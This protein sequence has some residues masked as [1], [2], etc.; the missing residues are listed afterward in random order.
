MRRLVGWWFVLL[1]STVTVG[2][3]IARNDNESR[4]VKHKTKDGW[5]VS[6]ANKKFADGKGGVYVEMQ[7]GTSLNDGIWAIVVPYDKFRDDDE[8]LVVDITANIALLPW[9]GRWN[10]E[11]LNLALPDATE[12]LNENGIHCRAI[13]VVRIMRFIR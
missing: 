6:Q 12:I 11:A 10:S 8:L 4:F 1:I 9:R 13:D 5:K 7:K 2:I 3:G